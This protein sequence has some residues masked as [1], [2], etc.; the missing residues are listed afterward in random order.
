MSGKDCIFSTP[1]AL[2]ISCALAAGTSQAAIITVDT[3]NDPGVA[4]ECSLRHAIETINAQVPVYG[5][6]CEPPDGTNDTIVFD[7][8]LSGTITLTEGRLGIYESMVIEGPGADVIAVDADGASGVMLIDSAEVTISGLTISGGS[9]NAGGGVYVAYD[10]QVWLSDCVISENYATS[11]GGGIHVFDAELSVSDCEIRGNMSGEHGGGLAVAMGTAHVSDSLVT[12][13]QAE[14]LGGGIFSADSYTTLQ[15]SELGNNLGGGVYAVDYGQFSAVL[16]RLENNHGGLVGGLACEEGTICLL[17]S[18]SVTGNEGELV[19]GLSSQIIANRKSGPDPGSMGFSPSGKGFEPLE[20]INSTISGNSGG[21]AG[22]ILAPLIELSHSTVAYNTQAGESPDWR[23]NGFPYAGGIG[24]T[25]LSTI[26]HSIISWNVSQVIPDL[27]IDEGEIFVEFSLVYDELGFTPD[28]NGAGNY[29]DTDPLLA[30]LGFN[31]SPYSLTH[32]LLDGSPII[33]RGNED[34]QSPPDYDQRGPGFD[35]IHG[36][37]MDIGAFESQPLNPQLSLSLTFLDF[38]SVLVGENDQRTLTITNEGPGQLYIDELVLG[39]VARGGGNGSSQSFSISEDN[40]SGQ[41]FDQDEFC[42]VELTFE[43]DA[44][45]SFNETLNILSNDANSPH[46]VGLAGV[47]VAPVLVIAPPGIDFNGV[48]IG[49][50]ADGSVTLTNEGEVPLT[51]TGT[52]VAAPFA[53]LVEPG[54]CLDGGSTI[55]PPSQSCDLVFT[56]TPTA[57]VFYFQDVEVFSDSLGGDQ[58]VELE[59]SGEPEPLPPMP[60]PAMNRITLALLGGGLMLLG[61]LGLRRRESAWRGTE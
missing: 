9:S 19:G 48:E 58:S 15:A 20:V 23:G 18:S 31:G 22:G 59:G 21:M 57:E 56:F 30:P 13:N 35:R 49:T 24:T 29:F 28:P 7:S 11:L 45:G 50:T 40:C 17:D 47:G 43:P 26:T 10:S 51:I 3:L 46:E 36:D 5:S 42:E 6:G 2:A 1:L 12:D 41:D 4:D 25:A 60:V 54:F 39:V 38:D 37:R 32:A 55:L 53:V 52:D 8:G 33:D 27:N 14:E 61:W 34:I 44:R 16:S